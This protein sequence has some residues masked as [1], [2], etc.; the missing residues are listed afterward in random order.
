MI[1]PGAVIIDVGKLNKTALAYVLIQVAC[2]DI[3]FLSSRAYK[4]AAA[5]W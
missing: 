2:N 3:Y 5:M 4:S 1:K